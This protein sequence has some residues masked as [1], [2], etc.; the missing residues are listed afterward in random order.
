MIAWQAAFGR[1]PSAEGLPPASPLP[2]TRRQIGREAVVFV[3]VALTFLLTFR[4]LVAEARWIPSGSMQS[5]LQVH[6]RVL[7]SKLS[8][9]L[10]DIRRG[11]IVVFARPTPPGEEPPPPPALLRHWLHSLAESLALVQPS[12]E[13]YIKRVIGLPG[14][15]VEGR[16]GRVFVDGHRLLEPY[17]DRGVTTSD[18]G[19]LRVPDGTL[20]VMGDNRAN[21]SDSRFIGPIPISKVVGRAVVR[22]WPPQR[23]SFL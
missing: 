2:A 18:F 13:D 22:M 6:D 8:Y 14:E 23:A 21:S 3:V 20:W 12:T 4:G 19:P 5:Q 9:R 7:V 1:A 11:D 15:M 10:H 16:R 17:L